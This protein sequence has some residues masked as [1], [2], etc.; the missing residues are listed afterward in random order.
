MGSEGQVLHFWPEMPGS[1]IVLSSEKPGLNRGVIWSDGKKA[2]IGKQTNFI[3]KN[4]VSS[5]KKTA[6]TITSES[7][8][9]F[10]SQVL[11]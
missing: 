7:H 1:L 11:P 8:A 2:A 10:P 5:S 6:W 4:A 9:R 3:K